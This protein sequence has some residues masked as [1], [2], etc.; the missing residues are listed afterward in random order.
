MKIIKYKDLNSLSKE[1]LI[2]H[3]CNLQ[4]ELSSKKY[5]LIW[6][7]ERERER[8]VVE[9]ETNFPVLKH[10][11]NNDIYSD[12]NTDP[13]ILIEGDNYHVLQ[14]LN[15]TH[16]GKIDVIYIDPPYNTGNK[17][18]LYNDKFI[19]HDDSYKH[20]K[21]LNFMEKRLRL[22]RSLLSPTGSI[23][24]SIDDHE[25]AN[26]KILCDQIFGENNFIKSLIWESGKP[27]GYTKVKSPVWPKCHEYILHYAKKKNN[28][29]IS[30]VYQEGEG[31]ELT[32]DGK[33]VRVSFKKDSGGNPIRTSSIIKAKE[34][35]I[36]STD[37]VCGSTGLDNFRFDT[38]KKPWRLIRKLL[39][40]T[41]KKNSIV[42]D[43]FAGSGTTA[44]AVNALNK[45][46]NGKRKFILCTNNENEIMSKY[47]YP[48]IK[49]NNIP[50]YFYKTHLIPHN[51]KIN[52]QDRL[53][54]SLN[55]GA[56]IGI[57]ENTNET[58]EI[59]N[60][61][62]LLKNKKNNK[63]TLIYFNEDLFK[64]EEALSKITANCKLYKFSYEPIEKD[65]FKIN[66]F[67]VKMEDIP[68][69]IIKMY[70]RIN[71]SRSK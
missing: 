64:W 2:S 5:G 36:Y 7:Q 58:V 38:G 50:I 10:I 13:N 29:H 41:S 15:F 33:K 37:W 71:Q 11:T 34:N 6:D 31:T 4:S 22:A 48:R 60:Y 35:N 68:E 66:N 39:L 17:D 24:I 23:F 27:F 45:E 51:E 12:E 61:Y 26:L 42:L 9:C 57:K 47:T 55:V 44:I 52:D 40:A 62:H 28:M 65:E 20:S 69:P 16:K 43:F 30:P 63:N 54:I 46:D 18:F 70:Q 49:E 56:L 14:C 25:H 53:N 32:Q 21:W 8:V 19:R 1:E 59:N 3:I 67:S